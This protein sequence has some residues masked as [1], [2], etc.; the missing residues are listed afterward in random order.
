MNNRRGKRGGSVWSKGARS[1]SNRLLSH[2]SITETTREHGKY[3]DCHNTILDDG[4]EVPV[5]NRS[6]EKKQHLKLF[7]PT[8]IESMELKGKKAEKVL[9]SNVNTVLS[10][11]M[12]AFTNQWVKMS[13]RH[14]LRQGNPFQMA[15]DIKRETSRTHRI[16]FDEDSSFRGQPKDTPSDKDTAGLGYDD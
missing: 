5:E 4:I 15:S 7:S 9:D 2:D 8:V 11:R 12:I 6:L 10:G 13:D 1:E 3:C 16:K 14:L